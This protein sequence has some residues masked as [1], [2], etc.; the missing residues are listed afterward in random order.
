[1]G[2]I[3]KTT[4]N[5]NERR[6]LI[7]SLVLIFVIQFASTG[8]QFA[9]C[10]RL[11]NNLSDAEKATAICAQANAS[12]AETGKLSLTTLLALLV[13]AASAGAMISVEPPARR[14]KS[15]EESETP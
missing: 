4:N 9:N 12:F 8:A 2:L 3:Q 5:F 7:R 14:R 15:P 10:F 1:M 13:P 6:F 11:S